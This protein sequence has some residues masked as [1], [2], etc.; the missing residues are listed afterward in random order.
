MCSTE[1]GVSALLTATVRHPAEEFSSWK[2]IIEYVVLSARVSSTANYRTAREEKINSSVAL[3]FQTTFRGGQ[4]LPRYGILP[5]DSGVA[6]SIKLSAVLFDGV[7]I[8]LARRPGQLR[9][10]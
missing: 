6:R 10:G 1:P 3:G 2:S 4:Y 5:L 9:G 8:R 7:R